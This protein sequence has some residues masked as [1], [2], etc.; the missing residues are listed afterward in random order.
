[1][2]VSRNIKNNIEKYATKT[3]IIKKESIDDLTSEELESFDYIFVP[4]IIHWE[5]R[6]TAWS[7]LPDKIEILIEVYDSNKNLL[8]SSSFSGESKSMTLGTTDP[9]ELVDEPVKE[10]ILSIF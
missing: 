6:A 7:A 3:K 10:F 1:M 9:T 8:I 2:Y 5:D 4:R